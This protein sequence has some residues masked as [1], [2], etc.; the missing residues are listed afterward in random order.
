MMDE[1]IQSTYVERGGI[2]AAVAL[3]TLAGYRLATRRRELEAMELEDARLAEQRELA[4][5]KREDLRRL[6]RLPWSSGASLPSSI[7][8]GR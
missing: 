1:D 6:Q 4:L 3:A 5:M 2:G 8:V 7:R